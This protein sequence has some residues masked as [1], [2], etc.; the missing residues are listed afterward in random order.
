M[1]VRTVL[2]I[3]NSEVVTLPAGSATALTG[4]AATRPNATRLALTVTPVGAIYI[5]GANVNASNGTP[6]AAGEKFP[7]DIMGGLYGFSAAGTTVA[8]LEGF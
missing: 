5:G 8:I 6:L 7:A 3:I 4:V 2:G 1:S